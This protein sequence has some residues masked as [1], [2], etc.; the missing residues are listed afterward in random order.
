MLSDR[1]V[2]Q[3]NLID[4]YP[5]TR[6]PG[7]SVGFAEADYTGRLPDGV[8]K[9]ELR[10]DK[11]VNAAKPFAPLEV[12]E[13]LTN[14]YQLRVSRTIFPQDEQRLT[15]VTWPEIKP[16]AA[17]DAAKGFVA[18]IDAAAEQ[19]NWRKAISG[20]ASRSQK[21]KEFAGAIPEQLKLTDG[22]L[23]KWVSAASP[24]DFV[25]AHRIDGDKHLLGFRG[26]VST[27]TARQLIELDSTNVEWANAVTAAA[28]KS[29][30]K[31]AGR[32]MGRYVATAARVFPNIYLFSTSHQ[33]PDANRDTFVMVCS[34]QPLDLKSLDETGDWNGGPFAALETSV[35]QSEPKL[36]GHMVAVIALAEGQILTDDFAPVD[37]LLV[38]VFESQE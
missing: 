29:R 20:L 27:A 11:T 32:F 3:A 1:G 16:P 7:T 18:E 23:E 34:R 31:G 22:P 26:L 8:V 5:R 35:G 24:F 4:I 13:L 33:Q 12:T 28:E 9:D 37:N 19:A 21:M 36:S 14:R 10:R 15:N 6:Y 17:F 25:E 2:F 38:P 30:S